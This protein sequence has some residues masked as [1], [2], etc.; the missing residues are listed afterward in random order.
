[1][2]GIVPKTYR[3]FPG[4]FQEK[5]LKSSVN[6]IGISW[7]R[8]RTFL[9]TFQDISKTCPGNVREMSRK[10]P[11]QQNG[12]GHGNFSGTRDFLDKKHLK[13]DQ[14]LD[15]LNFY[16]WNRGKNQEKPK[17]NHKKPKQQEK[18]HQSL[19]L[20]LI[21]TFLIKANRCS[22]RL[23]LSGYFRPLRQNTQ[24]WLG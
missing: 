18:S 10:S 3:K 5:S 14:G 15:F 7:T 23:T 12:F 24:P 21:Q 9:E 1:M 16:Q 22:Y 20:I 2:P 17:K 13:F 11:T 19:A 8:R 4:M 6:F